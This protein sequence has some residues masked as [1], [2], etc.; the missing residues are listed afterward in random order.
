MSLRSRIF[1]RVAPAL[2][3]RA[4]VGR[5]AMVTAEAFRSAPRKVSDL[6]CLVSFTAEQAEAALRAG[7]GTA[8]IEERLLS[9]ARRLGR[10]IRFWLG[11]RD[12]GAAMAVARTVYGMLSI[13]FRA[14]A[15]GRFTVSRCRF[16]S[17]YTPAVCRLISSIDRGLVSGLTNGARMT[18]TRRI[19]E[20]SP[21]CAGE[22]R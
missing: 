9:G 10:S 12:A 11:I 3:G 15:A 19:T 21:V 20:G 18:F 5:L 22:V 8:E 1:Q 4:C 6:D 13:D 7:C 17:C 2:L 16:S 14:D